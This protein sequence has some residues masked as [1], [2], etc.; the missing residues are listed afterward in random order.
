MKTLSA[1]SIIYDDECPLCS[2]YTSGFVY[3]KMLDDKGRIPF[4]ALPKN[5]EN[6]IDKMRACNEIALIDHKTGNVTYGVETLF[7]I[8]ANRYPF[9]KKLFSFTPFAFT[10][11]ILYAFISYNRKVIVP[12]RVFESPGQ[13]T[14]AFH[15]GYRWAY[16]V[17]AWVITSLILSRYAFLLFDFVRPGNFCREFLICGGQIVFQAMAVYFL[18]KARLVHY[19]G[20]MMTISLGGAILLIPALLA[21][22][23]DW[24]NNNLFYLGWFGVVVGLMFFEHLRRTRHL[25][26]NVMASASWVIY[27]MLVLALIFYIF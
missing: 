12:G 26:I 9:L 22:Q 27:R 23:Y 16:I 15:L 5:L 21:N 10:M 8:L 20:N 3:T 14:P 13:C 18:R 4:S 25:E 19:L 24:I 11:N 1:H 2:A 17:F 6:T 7:K